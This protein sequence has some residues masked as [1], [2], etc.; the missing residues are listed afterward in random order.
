MVQLS[1][2]QVQTIQDSVQRAMRATEQ[3]ERLCAAAARA[4]GDAR[5]RLQECGGSVL[6]EL[7]RVTLGGR[8]PE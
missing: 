4:F 6:G 3:T 2:Q 5:R 1:M 7:M 8:P